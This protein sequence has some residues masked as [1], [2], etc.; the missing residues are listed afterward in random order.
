MPFRLPLHL[1]RSWHGV[2]YFRF[3]VP[4]NLRDFAGKSEVRFSLQTEQRQAAIIDALPLIADLPRLVGCLQRMADNDESPPQALM[5]L[6]CLFVVSHPIAFRT[7]FGKVSV[8]SQRLRACSCASESGL[9]RRTVSPLSQAL[10]N[11]ITSELE[12]LQVKWA[13]QAPTK[14]SLPDCPNFWPLSTRKVIGLGQESSMPYPS[15]SLRQ[16]HIV[17]KAPA[18]A[19]RKLLHIHL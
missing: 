15:S 10:P 9:V 13:V 19:W 4:K 8:N 16:L 14:A 6:K 1:F 5:R 11:R 18:V 17:A 2:F 12:Y 7:V 3:V